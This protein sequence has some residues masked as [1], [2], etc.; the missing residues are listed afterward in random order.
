MAPVPPITS[1]ASATV[2]AVSSVGQSR[3]WGGPAVATAASMAASAP[4]SCSTAA[5]GRFFGKGSR[6]EGS[7]TVG[8]GAS[9]H[10]VP[11]RLG[12]AAVQTQR[13]PCRDAFRSEER[14]LGKECVRP[15]RSRL[16]PHPL[17]KKQQNKS[18]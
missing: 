2:A 7:F 14:R 16:F 12:P 11:S 18:Y 10:A 4:T 1:T 15:C 9:R 3:C 5:D 8:Y 6:I 17:Q 13:R